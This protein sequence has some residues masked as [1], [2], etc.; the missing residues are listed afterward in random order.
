M[1]R[2]PGRAAHRVLHVAAALTLLCLSPGALPG[3][4]QAQNRDPRRT[5]TIESRQASLRG[6]RRTESRPRS[7][8]EE[9]PAYRV[10][11]A[12]L[13]RLQQ[14]NYRL[15][16]MA[17]AAAA[18]DYGQIRKQAAQLRKS[19]ARLK[20]NLSLPQPEKGEKPKKEE[21]EPGPEDLKAA[22]AD[23]DSLV[24]TLSSNPI[25]NLSGVLDVEHSV[26]ARRDLE[27]IIKLSGRIQK[28]AESLSRA[29]GKKP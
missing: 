15:S 5:E 3:P 29:A 22:I 28:H 7:E 26:N 10:I 1:S 4:A 21:Q 6:L 12:D 23:L 24:R 19:A 8:S 14:T 2:Q 9:L 17:G 18:L 27:E 16:E 20:T 25:F 13:A 11:E